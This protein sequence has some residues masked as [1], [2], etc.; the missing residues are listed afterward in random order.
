MFSEQHTPD[1]VTTYEVAREILGRRLGQALAAKRAAT[2]PLERERHAAA[3][4]AVVQRRQALRV[5]SPEAD[6]IVA[7]AKAARTAALARG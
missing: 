7:D 1:Q 4:T 3:V 6:R 2:D 5:G